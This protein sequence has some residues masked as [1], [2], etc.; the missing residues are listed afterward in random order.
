[1]LGVQTKVVLE[2]VPLYGIDVEDSRGAYTALVTR[3]ITVHGDLGVVV[4]DG[5]GKCSGLVQGDRGDEGWSVVGSMMNW[6]D[7]FDNVRVYVE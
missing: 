6:R 5:L 7:G 4:V 2:R 1:M 3:A